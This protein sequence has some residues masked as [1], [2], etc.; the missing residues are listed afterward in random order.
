MLGL[1][2]FAQNHCM[3]AFIL[4]HRVPTKKH[5]S[6]AAG[7][8]EDL[9]RAIALVKHN[10]Q[11]WNLNPDRVGAVGF[12][13]GSLMI[14]KAALDTRSYEALDDV[15]K[16]VRRPD[17]IMLIYSAPLIDFNGGAKS[18]I[19]GMQPTKDS[20][21]A[22]VVHARDDYIPVENALTLARLYNEADAP[23][24]CHIFDTGGHG[25]GART[26]ADAPITNWPRLCKSWMKDNGWLESRD[27]PEDHEP[28]DLA[29]LIQMR[30][31]QVPAPAEPK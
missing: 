2:A 19:D 31:Q 27:R 30:L 22:F 15:D 21:N 25:F 9:Q 18:L 23:V 14:L 12:S 16:Q 10:A 3:L 24:E 26:I 8:T 11:Q 4:K 5:A 28:P 6:P 7:P 17:F 29:Q 13:S 20:P 1:G